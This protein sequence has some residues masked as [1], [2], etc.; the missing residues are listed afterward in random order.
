MAKEIKKTKT[1]KRS[2]T[3][4]M[5][6]GS[7][8]ITV[9]QAKATLKAK[10]KG[11]HRKS[12]GGASSEAQ[13]KAVAMAGA[14]IGALT[15]PKGPLSPTSE[16]L[17]KIPGHDVLGAEGVIAVAAHLYGKG[18]SGTIT[19]LRNLAAGMAVANMVKSKMA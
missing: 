7:A 4:M 5:V 18:K 13:L 8:P 1:A 2:S 3:G 11:G 6:R 10:G 9:A 12:G 14:I 15:S 19:N 16:T 17:A